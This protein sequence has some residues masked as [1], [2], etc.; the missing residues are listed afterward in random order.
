[1][2]SAHPNVGNERGRFRARV[3]RYFEDEIVPDFADG[4]RPEGGERYRDLVYKLGA[5][6]WL[7][8]GLPLEWGGQAAPFHQELIFAEEAI[9]AG[10]P[11]PHITLGTIAP[12]LTRFGTSAQQT[13]LLPGIVSGDVLFSIGY[14]EPEAGTDL[15]SLKTTATLDG[16][17]FVIRGQKSYTSQIQ[18][19]SH[20]WLAARTDPSAPA[21]RGISIFIVPTSSDGFSWTPLE[22]LGDVVASTTYYDDVTVP[23]SNLVGDLNDGWRLITNQL[24]RERILLF[25]LVGVEACLHQTVT[26][27]SHE[28][29]VEARRLIDEPWVKMALAEVASITDAGRAMMW[30]AAD[31]LEAGTLTPSQASTVKIFTTEGVLTGYRRLAEVL[32]ARG[33]IKAGSPHAVLRGRVEQHFR[34]ALVHLFGGGAN[35]VLRM[36]ISRGLGMPRTI[37]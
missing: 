5:D 21:H 14:T 19:A 3:A 37:S 2:P 25:S 36:I 35:D 33:R 28:A 17:T 31:R 22:V 26:W 20:V 24:N 15:A 29:G 12:L 8:L 4:V 23:R 1:M 32:G 10:I 34:H 9:R 16:D 11:L 30:D 6:G 18:Y 13:E 7:G 27:A